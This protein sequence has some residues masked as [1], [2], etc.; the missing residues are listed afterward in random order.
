MKKA[1]CK[2]CILQILINLLVFIGDTFNTGQAGIILR[3]MGRASF[4]ETHHYMS[5]MMGFT[6]RLKK[7]ALRSTHPTGYFFAKRWIDTYENPLLRRVAEERELSGLEAYDGKINSFKKKGLK[8]LEFTI[9]NKADCI[10][11]IQ[12]SLEQGLQEIKEMQ[13]GER[14]E[15]ELK[16]FLDEL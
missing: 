13:S 6:A 11:K 4:C 10:D 12:K 7:Q 16:S 8:M 3:R 9:N 2:K 14:P 5:K 15:Q 1:V